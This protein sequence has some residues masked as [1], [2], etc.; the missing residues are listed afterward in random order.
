ME[1]RIAHLRQ[2]LEVE[3]VAEVRRILREDA[4]PEEQE[5]GGVLALQGELELGLVLVEI[6]EMRHG[7]SV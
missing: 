1:E 4:V 3:L 7:E 6:V 2:R 5:D